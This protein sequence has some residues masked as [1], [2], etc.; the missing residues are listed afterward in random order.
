[1]IVSTNMVIIKSVNVLYNVRVTKFES[2]RC[3]ECWGSSRPC[4]LLRRL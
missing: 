2:M 3:P 4:S 1:M